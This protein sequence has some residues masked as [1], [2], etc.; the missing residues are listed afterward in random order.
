MPDGRRPLPGPNASVGIVPP[1]TPENALWRKISHIVDL[2]YGTP[3]EV[4]LRV[5]LM[6]IGAA[7]LFYLEGDVV[8]FLWIAT[9]ALLLWAGFF[10]VRRVVAPG[11]LRDYRI[12]VALI[13]VQSVVFIAIAPYS[14]LVVPPEAVAGSFAIIAGY[15]FFNRS[16]QVSEP[17]ILAW[18]ASLTV[19]ATLLT[20]WIFIEGSSDKN[21]AAVV[22]GVTML[23][24][25]YASYS[26]WDGLRRA[27]LQREIDRRAVAAQRS[28]AVGQLAAGMAHEFNNILAGIQGHLE[29]AEID[30]DPAARRESLR[31]AR[32][33]TARAARHVRQLLSFAR[34]APVEPRDTNLGGMLRGCEPLFAGLLG[35]GRQL[36]IDAPPTSI[37]ARVDPTAL[38]SALANLVLNSRDVGAEEVSLTLTRETFAAPTRV[39]E[40]GLLLH[41]AYAVLTVSD[42]GPGIPQSEISRVTE[43]FYTTKPVGKGTGLGLSMARGT[44]EQLGGGLRIRS[45]S[46]GARVAILLPE[47]ESDST[48]PPPPRRDGPVS[49]HP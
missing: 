23:V 25:I 42:D 10:H 22:V 5:S 27:L 35:S 3:G 46:I 43:P 20:G 2:H 18:E 32:D 41:G 40:D 4:I 15:A 16:R 49:L 48:I 24:A 28:E 8:G 34:K 38:E 21:M 45:T 6:A 17:V 19:L 14:A 13:M 12:T 30:P 31:S 9:Y 1:A 26:A 33:G 47:I 11:Q 39:A 29:L 44:A 36:I 37:Y 7:L